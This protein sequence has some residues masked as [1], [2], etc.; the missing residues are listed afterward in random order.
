MEETLRRER[1]GGKDEGWR[2]RF[3]LLAHL[4]VDLLSMPLPPTCLST[5]GVGP[6]VTF[7]INST[8]EETFQC[9]WQ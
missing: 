8:G 4:V 5:V 7:E 9:Q 2:D 6:N 3:V 1:E